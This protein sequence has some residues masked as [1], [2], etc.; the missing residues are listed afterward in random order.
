MSKPGPVPPDAAPRATGI[1]TRSGRGISPFHPWHRGGSGL[2]ALFGILLAAVVLP[3]LFAAL[4]FVRLLSGPLDLSWL[5]HRLL[6]LHLSGGATLQVDRASLALVPHDP[7]GPSPLSGAVP[8]RHPGLAAAIQL[9]GLAVRDRDGHVADRVAGLRATLAAVPLLRGR[10]VPRDVVLS[11]AS[12]LLR[13]DPDGRISLAAE[14]PHPPRPPSRRRG[15]AS[16][17]LDWSELRELRADRVSVSVRDRALVQDREVEWGVRA[18]SAEL[19]PVPGGLSGHLDAAA[20]LANQSTTLHA[21]GAPDPAPGSPA[22]PGTLVWHLSATPLDPAALS[23]I[24]PGLRALDLPITPALAV[25]FAATP[26]RFMDPAAAT[27]TLALG[28]GTVQAGGSAIGLH[29][30]TLAATLTL[31]GADPDPLRRAARLALDRAEL[32]LQDRRGL[33]ANG[34]VPAPTLSGTGSLDLD[35]LL[36]PRRIRAGLSVRSTLLDFSTLAAYWPEGA[37]K[38][39]R[40]WIL[41]NIT[42]G[43]AANL[44]VETRLA[45]DAGWGA[46]RETDRSGGFDAHDLELWWLRPIP[47]LEHMEA[48]LLFDGPDAVRIDA[49][50]ATLPVSPNGPLRGPAA[51]RVRSGTMRITGLNEHEQI[52]TIAVNLSGSV[53]ALLGE[54]SH[55]RLRL[56]S[57]HPL[58]FTNPSGHAESEVSVTLPLEAKV[59]TE[60]IRLVARDHLTDLHL[61]NVVAGRALDRGNIR[62]RATTDGLDLSGT[63]VLDNI[64]ARLRY[65]RDFRS[66]PPDQPTETAQVSATVTTAILRAEGLDPRDRLS[67]TAALSVDYAAR[68]DGE[69]RI[70]LGLDMADLGVSTE[71]W[72]KPRGIP[73]T[74]DAAITLLHGRLRSIDHL[75]ADG[76]ELSVHGRAE[77]RGGHAE[78]VVVGDFRVGRS[79]GSGSIV[80]PPPASP[81]ARPGGSA[82]PIRVAAHGP[83]LDLSAVFASKPPSAAPAPKRRRPLPPTPWTADLAFDRVYVGP[84][85]SFSAVRATI[86]DDGVRMRRVRLDAAGPTPVSVR[87]DPVSEGRHLS[88]SVADTG[89][90]L[91]ALGVTDRFSGG[92]LLLD[93]SFDDRMNASPLSGTV[94][95]GPFLMPDAPRAARMA[96]DLTLYGWLAAPPSP[97]M[98][99]DRFSVPFRYDGDLL[100]IHDARANNAALGVTATGGIDL[101]RDRIALRGTLVPAWA[102][103]RLPGTLPLVGRLFSPEKGGGLFA[104]TFA[105]TGPLGNP[106]VKVNPWSLLLPGALRR[107]LP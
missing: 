56:L 34:L 40:R 18:L 29:A 15:A 107:L 60:Q 77:V 97:G 57:R 12:V 91:A 100:S 50:S 104:A 28:A 35:R 72:N 105:V 98:R 38:G 45:S 58:P 63:A 74:A 83:A 84:S 1:G 5:A 37:A 39:A 43:Q 36:E 65:G 11:D 22:G 2:R 49:T 53:P 14:P 86:D 6:P 52:G 32:A 66:G 13:R 26:G 27:L 44:S 59:T 64:P 93:G 88:G 41:A 101:R 99:I 71:V 85:R 79:A 87:L 96:R 16:P 92:R 42:A 78:R 23:A 69:A 25:R 89:R 51:L 21:A 9:S 31:S 17:A 81:G 7:S 47:P 95:I 46:L 3:V 20:F 67:G 48:R 73:A 19:Q 106:K 8:R 80:L 33:S 54:L 10:V 62:V 68:R 30:G 94:E 55:P 102:I 70:G 61:G 90:L 4:L 82:A 103:N 24:L 75:R 76:P